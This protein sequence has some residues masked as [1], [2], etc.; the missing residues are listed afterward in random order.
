MFDFEIIRTAL[1]AS[2]IITIHDLII[3]FFAHL[4]R[5]YVATAVGA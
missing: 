3:L 2:I 5:T 4:D 1:L